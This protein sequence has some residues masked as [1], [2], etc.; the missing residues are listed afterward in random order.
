MPAIGAA[1]AIARY[2][3]SV[4]R[5]HSVSG[6]RNNRY[7]AFVSRAPWFQAG[8]RYRFVGFS[9]SRASGCAATAARC[10]SSLEALSIT[11]TSTATSP[12]W[13]S[14]DARQR[15]SQAPAL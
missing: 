4:P 7:G 12:R 3:S 6:F 9:I 10:E 15:S 13:R 2:S 5:H 8:D 14:S 1:A 11:S